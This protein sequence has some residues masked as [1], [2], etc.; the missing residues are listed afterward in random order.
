VRE[1]LSGPWRRWWRAGWRDAAAASA[2]RS[3][4]SPRPAPGGRR[5]AGPGRPPHRHQWAAFRL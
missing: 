2:R 4:G 3:A 5:P 1:S